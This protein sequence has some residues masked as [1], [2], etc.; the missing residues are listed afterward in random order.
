MAAASGA[1]SEIRIIPLMKPS[2]QLFIECI[3]KKDGGILLKT[4]RIQKQLGTIHPLRS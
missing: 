4:I 1:N 2:I 3:L